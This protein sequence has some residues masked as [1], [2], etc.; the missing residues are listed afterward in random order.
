METSGN[1]LP[2]RLHPHESVTKG[3]SQRG[4]SPAPK[5]M[6]AM[7]NDTNPNAMDTSAGR[8]RGCVTGNEEMNPATMPRRGYFP[9]GGFLQ[10]GQGGGRQRDLCEVECYTC[11]KKGHLSRNCPQHTWN[12]SNNNQCNWTL[13]PSQGREAVV[14]DRSIC[15]DE[16][17]MG[18][19]PNN[20]TPQ[21]QANTWLR[22]M[23]AVG[24]D[25][26]E[27]VM[28]DLVGREGFQNA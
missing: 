2:A 6:D 24:E 21:Q 9:Q 18:E 20:Q 7:T 11:H 4:S 3:T 23:A 5:R 19:R 28:R 14:D 25:V 13:H 8:T 12:R 22:G 16:Q 27:L 15:D 1:K 26:Q 10:R 17:T